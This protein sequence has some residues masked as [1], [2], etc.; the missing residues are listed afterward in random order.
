MTLLF[1]CSGKHIIEGNTITML[2]KMISLS[3]SINYFF[4]PTFQPT[5]FEEGQITLVKCMNIFFFI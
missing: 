3:I 2:C 5:Y 1:P 4:S